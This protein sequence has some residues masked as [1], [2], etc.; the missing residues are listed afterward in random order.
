[1]FFSATHPLINNLV[2]SY[3]IVWFLG[4]P[5]IRTANYIL[6]PMDLTDL[7]AMKSFVEEGHVDL[8]YLY[9]IDQM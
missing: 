4:D 3:P 1:M 6:Q 5:S 8:E 7:A 2:S 9:Y